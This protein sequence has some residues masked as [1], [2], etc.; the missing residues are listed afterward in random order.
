[1]TLLKQYFH[2]DDGMALP[3]IQATLTAQV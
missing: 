1:V 3:R 2:L